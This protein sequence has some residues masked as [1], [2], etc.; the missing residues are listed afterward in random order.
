MNG[1][2]NELIIET[3]R[4]DLWVEVMASYP[5]KNGIL[6]VYQWFKRSALNLPHH[7]SPV[8]TCTIDLINCI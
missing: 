4:A 3:V 5:L 1:I 8:L 6:N 2:I 7:S